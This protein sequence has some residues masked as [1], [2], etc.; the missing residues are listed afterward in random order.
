[1]RRD[2]LTEFHYILPITN[3]LSVGQIGL[4]SHNRAKKVPHDSVAMQE[5]QDIRAKVKL[6]TGRPLHDYVNL[7]FDAHNPMM[8]KDSE[9]HQDL[10]I[11]RINTDILDIPDVIIAD[12]NAS[13]AY[14]AFRPSPRG[15]ESVES[16]LVFA[17]YWTHQNQID[18][19]QHKAIKCAEVL[20][21]DR[22]DPQHIIGLY[23]SCPE[24]LEILQPMSDNLG[25][26]T[27]VA[28]NEYLFLRGGR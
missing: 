8:M 27:T 5:I 22:V 23:A 14:A 6:P 12:R 26:T 11:L 25:L 24:S 28:I 2:Q 15:L 17:E 18:Y 9:M 3:L 19:W 20:V 21:P 1:M 13:S 4:V 10:C 7:Y 16:D